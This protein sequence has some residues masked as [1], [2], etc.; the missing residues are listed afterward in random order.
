VNRRKWAAL[1]LVTAASVAGLVGCGSE[2]KRVFLEKPNADGTL[3]AVLATREG[4]HATVGATIY[5]Y[6]RSGD[7]G[8]SRR[9]VA[10]FQK[11]K[12]ISVEWAGKRELRLLHDPDARVAGFSNR[13]WFE[14]AN[15]EVGEVR[16][17]LVEQRGLDAPR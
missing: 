9:E 1:A 6:I 5:C 2:R 14:E 16:I 17:R 13:Y 3:T 11:V 4:I 12:G 10:A 15:G 7:K 8:S